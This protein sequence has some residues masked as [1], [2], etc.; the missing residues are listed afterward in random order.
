M[1]R[2]Y[3]IR[4]CEALGNAKRLF[5]GSTDLDI[6]EMGAK[7]LEYLKERFS[8]I[9]LDCVYTSPLI[10]AR[11]TAEAVAYGKNIEVRECA[12]LKEIDGGVVEGKPF[13]ETFAAMPELA[14]QWNNHPQDFAP[15]GGEPMRHAYERVWEAVMQIVS[16]N[17]GKNIAAATHGGL[18]RCLICRL[19]TGSIENLASIPWSENTSVALIEFDDELNPDLKYFNDHSHVPDEYM[20]KRNRL[21]DFM[22]RAGK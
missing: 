6:S 8:E 19:Q 20:P 4:H 22:Q 16:E 3:L 7:Q 14:E 17:K 9:P 21:S 15:E 5:Q 13:Q 2:L 18:L 10:R 11:K 1:T 12:G